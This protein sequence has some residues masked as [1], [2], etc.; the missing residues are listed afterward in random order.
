MD[1]EQTIK[2]L[3]SLIL[4]NKLLMYAGKDNESMLRADIEA[5]D[6]AIQ[7]IKIV[8]RIVAV[9]YEATNLNSE[10]AYSIDID[11]A[12]EAIERIVYEVEP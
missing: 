5:L 7:A 4:N 12:F 9:V 3:E 8:N 2:Q 6:K 10:G 1:I 11:E